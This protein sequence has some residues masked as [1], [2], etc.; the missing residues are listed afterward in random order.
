MARSS[1]SFKPNNTMG[2]KPRRRIAY[3]AIFTKG[4]ET[5]GEKFLDKIIQHRDGKDPGLSL[6]ACDLFFKY[7][8]PPEREEFPL[9][10]DTSFFRN[11]GLSLEEGVK[12]REALKE[13]Q[14]QFVETFVQQ[15]QNQG[16]A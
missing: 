6:K 2:K 12:L 15:L 4:L 16:Q 8:R 5:E 10:V 9:E 7:A 13:N 14:Q 1:T 3:D 11:L